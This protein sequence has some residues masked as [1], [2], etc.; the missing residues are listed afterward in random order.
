MCTFNGQK[1]FFDPE[2]NEILMSVVFSLISTSNVPVILGS[3][4]D[5]V[6]N[7]DILSCLRGV[8]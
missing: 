2:S 5:I 6:E 4:S 8:K 3:T 1:I 7:I